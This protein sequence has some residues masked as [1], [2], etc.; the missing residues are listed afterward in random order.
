MIKTDEQGNLYTLS[1]NSGYF[2]I[3]DFP[4]IN[5]KL[6]VVFNGDSD[7][8]KE[9]DV[10]GQTDVLIKL[11][12]TDIDNIGIGVHHWYVDL[13]YGEEKDTIIYNTITVVEKD[14]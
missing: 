4:K 10:K 3:K 12:K 14:E 1:D 11:S 9:F 13:I 6:R 8:V 7:V 2:T 5:G